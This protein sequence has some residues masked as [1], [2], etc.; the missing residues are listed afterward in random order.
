[1]MVAF[2]HTAEQPSSIAIDESG[3]IYIADFGSSSSTSKIIKYG[4]LNGG[5]AVNGGGYNQGYG[6]PAYG[7]PNYNQPAYGQPSYGQPAYGQP[8]YGSYNAPVQQQQPA[9]GAYNAPMQQQQPVYPVAAPAQNT[10]R[11]QY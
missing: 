2:Q 3:N 10:S 7:Q 4:P 11:R 8:S 6:Q 9:Y 1:L 5:N